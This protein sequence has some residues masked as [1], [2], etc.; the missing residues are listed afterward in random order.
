MQTALLC[1]CPMIHLGQCVKNKHNKED[2]EKTIK[3]PG[4]CVYFWCFLRI[5]QKA[6]AGRASRVLE[7][8]RIIGRNEVTTLNHQVSES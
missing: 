7:Y 4:C 5:K 1:V 2:N 6:N 3:V 8:L